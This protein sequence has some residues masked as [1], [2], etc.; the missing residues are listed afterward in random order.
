MGSSFP[1]W[2]VA[3]RA[4]ITGLCKDRAHRSTGRNLRTRQ[5]PKVE[6]AAPLLESIELF[7]KLD[8]VR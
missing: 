5:K 6:K 3:Q 7:K 1:R 8:M 2:A 4:E